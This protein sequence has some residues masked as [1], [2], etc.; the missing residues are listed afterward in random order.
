MTLLL[1]DADM[2]AYREAAAAQEAVD[3]DG[4]WAAMIVNIERAKA[5]VRSTLAELKNRSGAT[6]MRLCWSDRD[7]NNIFRRSRVY[8]DYKTNRRGGRYA[9]L[10]LDALIAWMKTEW[11][12]E[13]LP[14]CEAD[15]VLGLLQDRP[16][17]PSI[18]ASDDKDLSQIPGAHIG[19]YGTAARPLEMFDV[20]PEEGWRLFLFQTL[21]G[22]ATDNYKGCPGVGPVKAYRVLG[23]SPTWEDVLGAFEAAG[24]TEQDALVQ[25]RCARILQKGEYDWAAMEARLWLP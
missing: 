7:R 17:V 2:V 5:S 24:L 18:I 14:E 11:D 4:E 25:A 21:T 9:P 16:G 20:T 10:Y 8:P 15:D 13:E 19:I 23:D 3:F 22:D 1:V 6:Y 12:S